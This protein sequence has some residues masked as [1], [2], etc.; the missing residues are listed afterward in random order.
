VRYNVGVNKRTILFII[1]CLLCLSPFLPAQKKK[2][3]KDLPLYYRKWLE[4]EVVYIIT[5]KEKDVYLQLETDR[6]RDIFVEAFWKQRDPTPNTPENEFKTEHYRRIAYANQWFGKGGPIQGW[7]TDQG[8]IY[9]LL[10]ES[11]HIL[12]FENEETINPVV[13]WFYDGMA[14]Y[15]LPNAFNVVFFKKDGAGGVYELYSPLRNGPQQLMMYYMGDMTEPTQA[16]QELYKLEPTIAGISLSLIPGEA[17]TSANPSMMSDIL[18]SQKIPSAPFVKVKDDYAEKLLRYKDVIEV[19]YTSNYIDSD[20]LIKVYQ[21]AAGLSFVHYLIEPKKLTFY[22]V[23]DRFRAE[24]QVNGKISDLKG[25]TVYQFERTEPLD[26]DVDTIKNIQAKLFSYQDL[27]PLIP[28]QYKINILWKNTMSREFTSVEADLLIPD[29]GAFS[30]SAPVLAFRADRNSK[31]RGSNKSFLLGNIQL[32]PSARNIF[33][34]SDTLSVFFQLHGLPADIKSRGA[35]EYTILKEGVKVHSLTRSLA[36]YPGQSDFFEEFPLAGY[37]P[38][39]YQIKIAVLNGEK[40]E[41]LSTQI[42]FDITP[43]A[44]IARPW[45]LSRPLPASNDPSFDAVLGIQYLNRNEPAK[46]RAL[47]ES[48]YRRDPN[49]KTFALDF[50][51][52]LFAAKEYAEVKKAALPFMNDDRKFD[53]LQIMG[54]TSQALGEYAEAIAYFKDDLARFGTN[55]LVLNAI[56][57]CYVKIGNTAEALVAFERSL[58]LNPNQENIKALVKSLKEKK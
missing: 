20:P 24:I 26:F 10:G 54:E 2:S 22:Q 19:E 30:M 3:P 1:I 32:V 40:V 12:K 43:A 42:M 4:E 31:Y 56:G 15:G 57:E 38:A 37:L 53:F 9:I 47:L 45:V 35:V 16:Y 29:P 41:K 49:S 6:E 34:P 21:D 51:R 55:L 48:A 27:F 11:K 52:V 17:D 23:Q 7:R 50:C 58:Q 39:Y 33:L 46:A 25:N 13:I 8:R 36:E 14:E 44:A 5:P 28:G 18:L